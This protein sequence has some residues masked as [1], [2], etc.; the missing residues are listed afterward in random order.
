MTSVS[1]DPRDSHGGPAAGEPGA[2]EPRVRL[3]GISEEP[4]DV[5]AVTAAVGDSACG[6]VDV[7]IGV[8]RDH[9]HG[10]R[11]GTLEYLA[12]PTA[13]RRLAELAETVAAELP[14]CALAA[15]HRT[16]PLAVGDL[17]VVVAASAAHRDAAFTA[18]RTLID[19]LKHEVPIWKAQVFEDGAQEWVGSC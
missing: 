9:D 16:G 12:H 13:A 10:R 19:R 14:G 6:G 17:A 3:T 2:A 7:F 4:L 8:V 15:V 1:A 18:C 5:A 11:V